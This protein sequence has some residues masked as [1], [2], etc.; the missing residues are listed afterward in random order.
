MATK[1]NRLGSWSYARA[2]GAVMAAAVARAANAAARSMADRRGPVRCGDRRSG[3]AAA[4]TGIGCISQPGEGPN[5]G[6]KILATIVLKYF[7]ECNNFSSF[8]EDFW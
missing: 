7:T 1:L 8:A 6:T 5:S 3:G 4:A 2:A